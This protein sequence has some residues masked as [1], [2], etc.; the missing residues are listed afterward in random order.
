V[1]VSLS[2]AIHGSAETGSAFERLLAQR[3]HALLVLTSP[4]VFGYS[5][6]H[7]GTRA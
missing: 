6:A 2:E 1:K 4:T 7:R 3:P 5:G